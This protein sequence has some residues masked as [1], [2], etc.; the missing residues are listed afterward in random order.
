MGPMRSGTTWFSLLLRHNFDLEVGEKWMGKHS[1]DEFFKGRWDGRQ[2]MKRYRTQKEEDETL[3]MLIH[4]NV[5]AWLASV[6]LYPFGAFHLRNRP[7]SEFIRSGFT[8][9]TERVRDDRH[10]ANF[11]EM[12]KLKMQCWRDMQDRVQNFVNCPWDGFVRETVEQLEI[13][14]EV[15]NLPLKQSQVEYIGDIKDERRLYYLNHHYMSDF[16]DEDIEFVLSQC[17][18]ETEAHFGYEYEE[19]VSANGM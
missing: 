8:S 1:P 10:Y 6:R 4:R 5:F 19:L 7:M 9:S 15:Y 12:R 2:R 14:K 11:I 17:D 13:V 3:F 18:L 16:T